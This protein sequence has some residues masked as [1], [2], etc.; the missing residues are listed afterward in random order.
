[1]TAEP[2]R[3]ACLLPSWALGDPPV[4]EAMLR[5]HVLRAIERGEIELA[6]GW[7]LVEIRTEAQ[8]SRY[9]GEHVIW[10]IGTTLGTRKPSAPASDI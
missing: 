10:A 2:V 3:F 1:M 9:G 5:S 6:E 8:Q 4:I 7:R